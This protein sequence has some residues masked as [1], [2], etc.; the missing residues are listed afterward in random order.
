MIGHLILGDQLF[1]QSYWK[2]KGPVFMA[3][4]LELC[5]HFKYH[6]HKIIFFLASMR[7]FAQE[8]KD[9]KIKLEYS[10]LEK[11]QKPFIER[12]EAWLKK[13]K[14]TELQ[15]FEI[16]DEFFEARV[17][18]LCREC[19]VTLSFQP[20]PKFLTSRDDF[21]AYLADSKKP[22]MKVF[23]ER[24]RKKSGVLMD[25]KGKPLGGKFSFDEDNRKKLPKD[26]TP[27]ALKNIE[28]SQIVDDV[29][30]LVDLHFKDHPGDVKNFWLATRREEAKLLAA[31]F[32]KKRLELFGDYE[33]ALTPDH[34]FVFHS[35]LS[36]YMNNGF[37]P[38]DMLLKQVPKLISKD[39]PLNSIE[40]FVR[41]IMG[42]RE[43]INGIYRNFN[44]QQAN[45]NFFKHE[46]LL[47][48]DWYEGTT[49]ID[50]LDDVIKKSERLGFAHH[51]ERLMVV[52]NIMLMCEIHPHEV[53][54]Y[55]MEMYVDSA[56]WVMGPNVWGMG[57]FSDGGIFATKPYL[58]GSNYIRKMSHYKEGPWCDIMDGL[59]WRFMEKH[60]EFFA[61]NMRMGAALGT[62][63]KMAPERRKKIFGAAESFIS[64]KTRAAL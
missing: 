8:L 9:Q 43:F 12:L 39:M 11:K 51:I 3:E 26:L 22:F 30:A 55:F 49:G 32:F 58:C 56:D 52:S 1:P 21:K 27:P 64:Q 40:G 13:M 4:D 17:V 47:T 35:V 28:S 25:S 61:K 38:P 16:D 57:Q 54:R 50:V 34:D 59:Y 6:K 19:D 37:L 23:Y 29:K 2:F 10:E 18:A 14:I 60:R 33:D 36:P 42:W 44:R 15:C 20:T 7:Q 48:R 45:S 62:L 41:Q 31:D 63:D 53:Y 46:R 24:Q 5:T